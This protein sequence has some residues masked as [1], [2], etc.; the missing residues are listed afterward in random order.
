MV[1]NMEKQSVEE[2]YDLNKLVTSEAIQKEL[3]T[4]ELINI[5]NSVQYLN[6]LL[7]G[8]ESKLKLIYRLIEDILI[9]ND[10]K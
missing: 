6:P 7:P 3:V 8:F 9:R 1:F 5:K 2:M 10:I 4:Q